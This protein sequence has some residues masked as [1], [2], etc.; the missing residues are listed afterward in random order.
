MPL[1]QPKHVLH[2]RHIGDREQRLRHAGG[3]RAKSSAFAPCHNNGFH[4]GCVLLRG[5][6]P[7]RSIKPFQREVYP[8]DIVRRTVA[9][10]DFSQIASQTVDGDEAEPPRTICRTWTA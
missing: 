5:G 10:W 7:V 6:G 8:E 9:T 4:Y 3:H 2:D 1:Q